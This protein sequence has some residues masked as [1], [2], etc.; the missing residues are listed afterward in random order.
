MP[1]PV[2]CTNGRTKPAAVGFPR[3]MEAE[4]LLRPSRVPDNGRRPPFAA[5]RASPAPATHLSC[6]GSATLIRAYRRPITSAAASSRPSGSR[7]SGL[8]GVLAASLTRGDLQAHLA[9]PRV[10]QQAPAPT[11]ASLLD[12]TNVN[13]ARDRFGETTARPALRQRRRKAGSSPRRG[14]PR[15]LRVVLRHERERDLAETGMPKET[16][17]STCSV[18]NWTAGAGMPRRF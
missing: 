4:D 5:R 14:S 9:V 13:S 15:T 2:L 7:G 3:P 6:A 18:V 17:C 11:L 8:A 16:T 10:A 12:G 1:L